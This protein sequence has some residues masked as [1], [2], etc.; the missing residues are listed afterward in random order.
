[1]S[2]AV[3]VGG[4]VLAAGSSRRFGGAK[5]LATFRGKPLVTHT[6]GVASD[7]RALG[8]LSII[9]VVTAAGNADLAELARESGAEIVENP[10]PSRGLS[11]SLRLGLTTMPRDAGAALILLGDQPLVRLDVIEAIVRTWRDRGADT[12]RPRY[13]ESPEV[14]GHP[15]LL[16]RSTWPLADRLEGDSGLAGLLE[17][18]TLPVTVVDV[19]GWNPDVDTPADLLSLEDSRP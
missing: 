7:A 5:L 11:S 18:R 8:L 3:G 4:I 17:S 19:P 10:D 16:D 1:M 9:H 2:K 13:A 15:V 14:P 6:L 12:V